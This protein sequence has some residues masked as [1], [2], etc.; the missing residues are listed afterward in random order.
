MT[1]NNGVDVSEAKDGGILKVVKKAGPD[2]DDVPWKGDRVTVHYTG[3]LE[4]GT[5]FDS[6]VDRG[7]KFQFNLG[8][9]EVIK[10]WDMG[11][12]SMAKGEVAVFT[13]KSDYAY[14]SS[15]SPPKIPPGA[16]LVFEIELFEFEG[17]DI[18]KSKD[19]GITKRIK[20]NGDGFDHPNV[21]LKIKLFNNSI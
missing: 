11:V 2:P 5:K 10:G 12:A 13:I 18:T 14:G 21:S 8:K 3:T 9:Q 4:D 17:E 20:Q 19:K 15:G 16:T 6:S 1:T 7:E